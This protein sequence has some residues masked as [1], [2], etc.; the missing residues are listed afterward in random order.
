MTRKNER[1]IDELRPIQFQLGIQK[2]PAGSVLVSFGD[3]VVLCAANVQDSV[4]EWIE[5]KGASHGWITAEYA[6]LP[7]AT[8]G[9]GSRQ[10]RGRSQEIQ[11]L[12]GRS[13]R[14]A[15]DLN[16][17]PGKTIILPRKDTLF[18][19]FGRKTDLALFWMW[20]RG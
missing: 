12:I 18:F 20:R 7:G 14:T 9:R 3:T 6:M 1:K 8:P 10:V 15:V 4:P 16:A 19:S 5:K 11:R 17:I 2:D 13:L